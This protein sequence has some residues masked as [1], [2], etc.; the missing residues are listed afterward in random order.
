MQVVDQ[1][2]AAAVGMASSK[3]IGKLGHQM[4]PCGSDFQVCRYA[5]EQS[6]YRT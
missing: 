1:F 2:I 4:W 5:T 3:N 6:G